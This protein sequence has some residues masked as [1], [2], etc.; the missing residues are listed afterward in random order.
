MPMKTSWRNTFRPDAGAGAFFTSI[1]V[2][3]VGV[4]C[5]Q[6]AMNN[7]LHEVHHMDGLNRGTLE[8]FREFPGLMLVFLLALLHKLSDWK[9]MRLGTFISMIGAALLVIP[10]ERFAAGKIAVTL[11]IMLWS[12]G[13]HLVL[14]VRSTIA[15]QVAK[16][17]YA[18]RSLGLLTSSHNFGMVAGSLIVMGIFFLG[19]RCLDL[20]GAALFDTVWVLIACLMLSSVAS[21][22]SRKAPNIPS[23]RPRL[24]FARKFSKFYALEL[25]YGARKQIFLTFAPYVIIREYGFSTAAMALLFGICAA[26]NIF[27]APQIGRLCDKWGYRNVMIWDTVVL[28]GVCL[29]YGFAGR[30]FSPGVALAVVCVNFLFDAV[31]STTA[32]ATS[33]YVRDLSKDSDEI[34]ATLS[35]GLSINHL[36]SILVAPLGGWVWIHWGVEWLFS[37]AAVMAVCNTL[38]AMTIPKPATRANDE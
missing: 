18:G 8:F 10:F 19:G 7:F 11:V 27:G 1:L 17:E 36:I 38:F 22:F 14:P 31:I 5:F 28:C 20:S 33:I 34:T 12:T 23:K 25:F 16:P 4:G 3:G 21:T 13:E 26:V 15:L 9:I 35:T 37:F 6:A 32:M 30:I 29:L 24:H 2:W